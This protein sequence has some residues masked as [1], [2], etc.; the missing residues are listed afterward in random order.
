MSVQSAPKYS[1]D[2]PFEDPI[3]RCDSCQAIFLREKI[4]KF[5]CCPECGN[6]RVRNVLV[7]KPDEFRKVKEMGIDPEFLAL[8]EEVGD[9]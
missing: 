6:R 7:M 9:E 8:F 4:H 1:K 3:I 2:A 5:G